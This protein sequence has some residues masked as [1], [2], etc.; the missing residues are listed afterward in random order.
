MLLNERGGLLSAT[1]AQR[2][3]ELVE[4]CSLFER[5]DI[6][7]LVHQGADQYTG[8]R[9]FDFTRYLKTV[10][11]FCWRLNNVATTKMNKL[12]FYADYVHFK[13]YAASLTGTAYRKLQW[14]PVPE[15]YGMLA[16]LMEMEGYVARQERTYREY[17]GVDYTAGPRALEIE[18]D[19]GDGELEVLTMIAEAFGSCS[20]KE[21]SDRSH[22]E[23]AWMD[24]PDKALISY[25]LAEYISTPEGP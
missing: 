10:V 24:T 9:P 2:T 13:V 23:R 16:D 6:N 12:L 5:L 8:F 21:I 15:H 20:A 3:K 17:V 4:R 11:W 1:Q 19:W 22:Q 18:N 7:S 14:G 25:M